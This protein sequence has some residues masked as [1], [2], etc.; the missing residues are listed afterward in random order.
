MMK[1]IPVQIIG[2][3]A[4]ESSEKFEISLSDPSGAVAV[5]SIASV[6]IVNDDCIGGSLSVYEVKLSYV[7]YT[8]FFGNNTDEC[9]IRRNGLVELRGLLSG[10]ENVGEYDDITYTGDLEMTIDM[11]ICSAHRLANGEDDLCGMRVCGSGTVF[12]VLEIY[13]GSDTTGAYDGRGGYI[14]IESKDTSTFARVVTGGC[15]DQLAKELT[16]VP[17]KSISSVFNGKE[18]PMLLDRTLKKGIHRETDEDG[19]ITEVLVLRKIR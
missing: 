10:I 18:L 15:S 1:K 3:I 9:G 16:M 5:D 8:S 2:E 14:K 11:D 17:N 12:T 13:F 6:T 19:N 4:C 7:G